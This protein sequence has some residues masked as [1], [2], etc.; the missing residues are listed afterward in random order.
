MPATAPPT[1]TADCLI[2]KTVPLA[3]WVCEMAGHPPVDSMIAFGRYR[4]VFITALIAWIASRGMYRM[5]TAVAAAREMGS[6]KLE[7]RLGKLRAQLKRRRAKRQ[8]IIDL[9]IQVAVNEA[10][11][12]GFL[13]RPTHGRFHWGFDFSHDSPFSSMQNSNGDVSITPPTPP[14]LNPNPAPAE[15]ADADA[16]ADAAAD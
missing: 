15:G 16:E 14:S 2:P 12:L 9:Q 4:T 8:E 1:G 7:E 10:D 6:Y 13:S 5:G 3:F 11:G